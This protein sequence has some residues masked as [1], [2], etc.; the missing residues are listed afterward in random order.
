[1]YYT[2]IYMY[3]YIYMLGMNFE[4]LFGSG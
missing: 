3:V 1:V 4:L 2:D